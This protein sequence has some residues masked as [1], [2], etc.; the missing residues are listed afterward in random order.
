MI[1]DPPKSWINMSPDYLVTFTPL[2]NSKKVGFTVGK[3]YKSL[4][5]TVDDCPSFKGRT[6]FYL[7][8]DDGDIRCESD[9]EFKIHKVFEMKDL[10]KVFDSIADSAA[11]EYFENNSTPNGVYDYA[12]NAMNMCL[13]KNECDI[14]SKL[15]LLQNKAKETNDQ[16]F[17]YYNDVVTVLEEYQD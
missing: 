16:S 6:L 5:T 10:I 13:S 17:D 1:K 9:T 11:S 14:L 3:N 2:P 15:L 4:H 7:I 12:F 8:D